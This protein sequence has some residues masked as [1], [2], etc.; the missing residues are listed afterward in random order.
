M[1]TAPKIVTIPDDDNDGAP[2]R[3][4]PCNPAIAEEYAANLK[5]I[6]LQF[7]ESVMEDHNDALLSAVNALKR[8]M[9]A[10]FEQMN[11]ADVE[12]VM[13]MINDTR[14]LTL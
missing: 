8:W 1:A 10:Q 11:P 13:Q 9:C 14:C 7:K 4:G 6:I 3:Q 5:N 2:P 12:I